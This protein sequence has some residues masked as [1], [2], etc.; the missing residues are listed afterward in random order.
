M[1]RV[2]LF[3]LTNIAVMITLGIVAN[4]ACAFLGTSLADII[5]PE[6]SYLAIFAFVYGMLGAIIS[7]L[8]S[9]PMAKFACGAKVVDGSEGPA[10]R[11]LVDTV[12]DL[13]RRANIKMPEVAV[14]QGAANAF[15]TGAFKNSALVAVSTDIMRQMTKEE[16]R[17]VL[18]HEISHVANGDMVT[19]TLVQGVLNAFV[20]FFSRMLARILSSN[21][22]N[23]RSSSGT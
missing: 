16:L 19:L 20:I 6:W 13:S 15:A 22:E 10:E 18:G 12:A 8:M 1:K 23:R 5:G 21:G 4:L 9:K 14:Y 2:L 7:L 11:W 3:L 17:A